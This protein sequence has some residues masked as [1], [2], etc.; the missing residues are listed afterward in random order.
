VLQLQTFVSVC[1]VIDVLINQ[2]YHG[3]DFCTFCFLSLTSFFSSLVRQRLIEF[4]FLEEQLSHMFCG[5]LVNIVKVI[6]SISD[7]VR[8]LLPLLAFYFEHLLFFSGFILALAFPSY[9]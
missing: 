7:I 5:I 3:S 6:A 4:K 1:N 8:K 9:L 2:I